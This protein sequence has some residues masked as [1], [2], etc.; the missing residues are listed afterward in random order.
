M[1]T[2]GDADVRHGGIKMGRRSLAA[3][4]ATAGIALAASQAHA[5]SFAGS[6]SLDYQNTDPGLVLEIEAI[7][8]TFA[9][10]LAPDDPGTPFVNEEVAIVPLFK[11][12]TNEDWA[13]S[14]DYAHANISLSFTF[15]DPTP[16]TVDP[17]LG[18]TYAASFFGVLQ[19]GVLSWDTGGTN[20]YFGNN[21]SGLL[22][23]DVNGG[24][25]NGGLVGLK[26]GERK[27]LVVY[28]T[29]DWDHDPTGVPE[30]ATWALMIMGFGL[31]GATLR[32]RRTLAA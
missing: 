29:F 22:S 20:F 23:I 18:E 14:D 6:W 2:S 5:G 26:P 25:F 17:I 28:G 32:H 30:P 19:H 27:G 21:L 15:T 11:I 8:P 10:N 13:N 31:A 24:D 9:F 16:N 3:L 1:S 12:Y 7:N 4:A